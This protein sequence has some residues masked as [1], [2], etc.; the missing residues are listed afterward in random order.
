MK[1]EENLKDAFGLIT[2][3]HIRGRRVLAVD[4]VMT[5]GATLQSFAKTLR[6]GEPQSLSAV[7]LA[8]ADPLGQGFEVI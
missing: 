2:D 5:T 7:V 8:V 4:D 6:F 3:R 1:R